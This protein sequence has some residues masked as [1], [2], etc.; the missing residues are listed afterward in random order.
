MKKEAVQV[1]TA[2]RKQFGHHSG[3]RRRKARELVVQASY[4]WQMTNADI[5]DIDNEFRNSEFIKKAD[6]DYFSQVF[7]GIARGKNNLDQTIAPFLDRE[8][9]KL[10]PIELAILRLGC[11]ELLHQLDLPY[12]VVINEGIELA[13]KF[14]GAASSHKYVNGILDKLASEVRAQEKCDSNQ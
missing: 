8:L 1:I 14:G 7:R 6:A 4:Q 2:K 5:S 12:R 13:K 11:F 9:S 3:K 10:D